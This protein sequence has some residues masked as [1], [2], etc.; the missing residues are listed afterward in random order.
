MRA[1][2]A[3]AATLGLLVCC[4]VAAE[5]LPLWEVGLGAGLFDFPDYRGSDER[6]GYLLPVPYLIYRGEHF[7]AD[8]RGIRSELLE[9]ERVKFNIS[10]GAS[11]PV[12]SSRN[13][14]RAG[15]PDLKPSIEAGPSLEFTLWRSA[16]G[17]LLELRLPVRAA[18]TLESSPNGI[19]WVATPNINI[20]WRGRG[21]L[22]GW[23]IGLFVGPVYGSRQHHEYYYSVAPEFA[24]PERPA[25]AASGGYGGAQFLAAASRRFNGYWVG[26]FFRADTLRGAVFAGSPLMRRDTYVAGGVAIA[27]ILGRSSERV[28]A[29]E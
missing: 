6:H 26:A 1:A 29:P 18:V 15:M 21:A 5:E 14:A 20:D 28:E 22:Q 10:F 23:N 27:W 11:L 3:L 25:Y 9:S 7:K 12:D 19:G 13:A 8:R 24:T 17:D 4:A 16:A 2:H